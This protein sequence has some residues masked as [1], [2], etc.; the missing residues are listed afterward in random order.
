MGHAGRVIKTVT[1]CM[2][3][4]PEREVNGDLNGWK[5]VGVK[6]W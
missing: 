3:S 2:K 6:A 5:K 4:N 1:L